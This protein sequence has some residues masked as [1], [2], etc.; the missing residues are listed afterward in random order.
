M[1]ACWQMAIA[2]T[3][4]GALR[5]RAAVR[6]YSP[7]TVEAYT[8]WSR[9]YIRH[10]G[11][12]H[13]RALGPEHVRAFLTY[14]TRERHVAASTQNQALAALQLLTRACCGRG[15]LPRPTRCRLIEAR[16]G[17]GRPRRRSARR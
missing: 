15:H 10:H 5:D 13:P 6:R 17:L 1:L 7:R 16:A 2:P 4:F 8:R 12:V 3:L 9:A 14:L 11:G